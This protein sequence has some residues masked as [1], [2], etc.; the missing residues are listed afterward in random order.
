M[1]R[2]AF[3]LILF[4]GCS[5]SPPPES[6]SGLPFPEPNPLIT[7]FWDEQTERIKAHEAFSPTDPSDWMIEYSARINRVLILP[8]HP[9]RDLVGPI[10]FETDAAFIAAIVRLTWPPSMLPS[11]TQHIDARRSWFHVPKIS[12][13]QW[14]ICIS[15]V[16]TKRISFENI[17]FFTIS[18][19]MT[20]N[21]QKVCNISSVCTL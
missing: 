3:A 12:P 1:K 20:K 7:K 16:L 19:K 10:M 21:E 9:E 14:E 13:R 6:Q 2:F 18:D 15:S 4:A 5:Q 11:S 17:G 8:Q